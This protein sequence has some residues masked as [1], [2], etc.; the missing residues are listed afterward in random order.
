MS[1]EENLS[2]CENCKQRCSAQAA[3]LVEDSQLDKD[4]LKRLGQEDDRNEVK[5]VKI[6]SQIAEIWRKILNEGLRKEVKTELLESYSRKSNLQ[7]EAPLLN[8][9]VEAMNEWNSEKKR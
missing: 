5:K 8:P 6:H 3:D 1:D 4:F 7:L 2:E 9:E